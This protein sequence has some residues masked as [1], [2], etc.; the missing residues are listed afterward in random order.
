MASGKKILTQVSTLTTGAALGVSPGNDVFTILKSKPSDQINIGIKWN[1]LFNLG[2]GIAFIGNNGRLELDRNGWEVIE[3]SKSP[4]KVIV[5]RQKL[6]DN[7][8][9]KDLENFVNIIYY[10]KMEELKC[11]IG[12]ASHVAMVSQVGNIVFRSGSKLYWDKS[13]SKF[14]DKAIKVKYFVAPCH[15]EYLLPKTVI[16]LNY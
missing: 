7:G 2:H 8:I 3:E 15:N 5:E 11:S 6:V 9:D 13:M 10:H 14:S 4:N 1:E 12:A 16:T